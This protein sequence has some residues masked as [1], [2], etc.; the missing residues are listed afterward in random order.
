MNLGHLRSSLHSIW[1]SGEAHESGIPTRFARI[2]PSGARRPTVHGVLLV[3]CLWWPS[4]EVLRDDRD[5]PTPQ[6]R[7][8]LEHSAEMVS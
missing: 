8:L 3:L 5:P 6:G 7:R 2:S 1:A 4:A